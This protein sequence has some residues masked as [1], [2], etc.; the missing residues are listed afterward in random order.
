[1][2]VE[3]RL[4]GL[5]PAQPSSRNHLPQSIM[6]PQP[7]IPAPSAQSGQ[8]GGIDSDIS[9]V[10]EL[11]ELVSSASGRDDPIARWWDNLVTQ[12]IPPVQSVNPTSG[13][14]ML[15]TFG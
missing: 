2:L 5:P 1:M 13:S 15:R 12:I 6:T 8:Q 10:C 3:G 11:A 4:R 9:L 14:A 7:A